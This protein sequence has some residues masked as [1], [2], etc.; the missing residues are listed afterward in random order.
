MATERINPDDVYPPFNDAYTQVVVGT[1]TRQVHVAGTL[2]ADRDRNLIGVGDQRAQA[3]AIM[4]V[5]GRSLAAA[6]ASAADVVRINI[7]TVDMADYFKGANAEVAAFFGDTKP[8]ST[9]VE[10][11]RLAGPDLLLEIQA[12][13]VLD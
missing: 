5:I 6:G 8:A 9:L 2:G 12:T 4:D 11:T 10:V 13:A 1:G 7:F 3:K